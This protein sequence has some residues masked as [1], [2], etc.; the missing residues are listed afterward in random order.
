[1]EKNGETR[2]PEGT[3]FLSD[4][5]NEKVFLKGKKIGKIS[6]LIIRD[7]D[8][9]AADVWAWTSLRGAPVPLPI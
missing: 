5:L 3:Y 6:D 1:M 8:K 2:L 9:V 4:V 7:K